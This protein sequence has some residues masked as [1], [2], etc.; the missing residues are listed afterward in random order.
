MKMGRN[1]YD[2]IVTPNM[3]GAFQLLNKTTSVGVHEIE[4]DGSSTRMLP[5]EVPDELTDPEVLRVSHVSAALWTK[6]NRRKVQ[7]SRAATQLKELEK[8]ARLPNIVNL[9]GEQPQL[10]FDLS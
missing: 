2:G 10:S 4:L 7:P 1:N 6:T 3:T 9:T 5:G 8:K